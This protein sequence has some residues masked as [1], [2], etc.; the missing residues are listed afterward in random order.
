M[1]ANAAPMAPN[2]KAATNNKSPTILTIHAIAT[3]S[4]GV[5]E[6]P[7]PLKIAPNKLYNPMNTIPQPRYT[8]KFAHMLHLVHEV[9]VLTA[10]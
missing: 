2:P 3:V 10:L 4:R 8:H 5:F 9:Y 7:I 1:V 6:S